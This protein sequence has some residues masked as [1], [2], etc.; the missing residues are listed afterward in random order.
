M[1]WIHLSIIVTCKNYVTEALQGNMNSMVSQ[2]DQNSTQW[3]SIL[4]LLYF[5]LLVW[6]DNFSCAPTVALC[7][8]LS[9]GK[10]PNLCYGKVPSL[11]THAQLGWLQDNLGQL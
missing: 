5:T 9:S 2:I 10:G 4:A 7:L 3:F 11:S 1:V 8:N 6:S